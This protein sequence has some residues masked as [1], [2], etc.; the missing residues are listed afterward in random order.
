MFV[1]LGLLV[2]PHEL[3]GVAALGSAVGVFMIIFGRPL[4]VVLCLAPFR[5]FSKNAIKYV[6]WIGLRGAVP[7]IFATYLFTEGVES[8]QTM[9]NIVFFIT[10]LS[11]VVQGMTVGKMARVFSVAD[12]SLE[13]VNSFGVEIPDEIRSAM[14]EILVDD[15]LLNGGDT[16]S[17]FPMPENTLVMMVRRGDSFFVPRGESKILPGDKLLVISDNTD[18]V[19]AALDEKHIRYYKL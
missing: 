3:L 10:I 6:S 15:S 5:R 4:S 12:D 9:F 16:L 18:A 7:I 17:K 14:V 11:L 1:L 19:S 2:N 8:A 13:E